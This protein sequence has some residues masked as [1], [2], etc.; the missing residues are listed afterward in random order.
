MSGQKQKSGLSR[1][2]EIAGTKKW[3]LV[4]SVL[5]AVLS[6]VAQ[7]TPFVSV[8]QILTEL[9]QHA[10]QPELID[11]E[12]VWHWAYMSIGGIVLF[13]LLLFASTMLSHIAAFNI[14][15]ELRVTL[16]RKL[17]RLPLGF[18]SKKS[19]GL[20]K[21]IMSEDVERVELFVAHHIPD[22][23]TAI[24]FPILLLSYMFYT[25]WHLALV[26]LVV[27][28]IAILF[29]A[30]MMMSPSK[31]EL[32][33]K[34]QEVQGRMNS[35]IVEYVRGIQV[36]KIF[37]RSTNAFVRLNNDIN[38]YRNLSVGVSKQYAP[39]YL[40]YYTILSSVLLFLIPAA[41]YF[42]VNSPSYSVFVPKA[43][44]FLILGG[45][46]FF[47]MMKLMWMSGF[48]MQN[49]TGVTLVDE[50]LN[51]EEIAEPEKPQSPRDSSVEFQNVSFA[52][53]QTPILKGISFKAKPG[54]V[55]ALVGPSGAGKSTVAMLTARFWDIQGGDILIGGVFIKNISTEKLMESVSFVFQDNMLFFDTL[56]ENIRMGNKTASFQQ[57]Q[58]AAKAAQCH[59]FIE[60]L[61]DGYKTLVGEGG[62]YLSGGEQQRIALA[63]AILKNAPIVLLDEATAY[64]D[65]ENE[66]KILESFSHLI[67]GKTVMVI[68][69]RL[70]TI[71]GADQILVVD[72]G[73]IAERGKHD[74]LLAKNGIYKQMWE[75]Y[76]QSREWTIKK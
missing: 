15:Y 58:T 34:Y 50:I 43:L 29:Q 72:K 24:V 20:I 53:D 27:F 66:G 36:V 46:M 11:K 59:E 31:R 9:A 48:M 21:K 47:P 71:T 6:A 14:L 41:T 28:I 8:Y 68:A 45:G 19:S 16:A 44:M 49:M 61:P 75:A 67:K 12:L 73:E 25:D 63:R 35:S 22:L 4:G 39:V 55:T 23:T 56:E 60:K 30:V 74:E 65:P 26:I 2:V 69:H 70:S 76:S 52:Y 40:G 54:T 64:A 62:T 18:F 7:F 32:Y 10:S 17:V 38:D 33:T 42:L 51:K 1:L 3:W 13:G 5:L 57:V 37:N